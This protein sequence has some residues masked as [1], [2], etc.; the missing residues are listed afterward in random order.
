MVVCMA[1]QVTNDPSLWLDV[2]PRPLFDAHKYDR[3]HAVVIAAPELTGATRLTAEACSRIGAG[4]VTVVASKRADV[5]RTALAADI[6]VTEDRS[7]VRRGA[8][9]YLLGPGGLP[10]A[11]EE[12]VDVAPPTAVAVLD[13]AAIREHAHLRPSFAYSIVT[14]HEGEFAQAFPEASG[15]REARAR[16]AATVADAIVVLKGA[17]S[18]IA[19]PDGRVVTN[20]NAS[21]YLAKAGSG[22]VLAGFITG[23]AAQGMPAFEAA[24]AAVWVHGELGGRIGP[25]LVPTDLVDR[26][27]ELLSELLEGD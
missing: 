15:D 27:P 9:A 24:C 11:W 25:G 20:T 3:G 14:P 13:A 10:D 26:L 5:Y 7:A 8:T 22:D 16:Q 12:V 21:P 18:L 4:L 2:F 17:A 23:L 19:A 1:A 6:M